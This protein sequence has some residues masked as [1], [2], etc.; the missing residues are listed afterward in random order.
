M[1]KLQKI[2]KKLKST[3]SD[4]KPYISEVNRFISKNEYCKLIRLD[5]PT[6]T[7]LALLPALWAI[8]FAAT[9]FWQILFYSIVFYFTATAVRGAGCIINDL[10]DI[11]YDKKVTRTKN[12]PL[13]SGAISKFEALKFLV[14]LSIFPLIVLVLLPK[15]SIITGFIAV[16]M[17]IIYPLMKRRTYFPQ[18]FLGLT[19]NLGVLIAWFA[20]DPRLS[21]TPFALYIAAAI[22]TISYDTIYGHQDI[23]DDLKV[24]IKS[25]S[26]Y[27]GDRTPEI[28]WKLYLATSV[29]I[30]I[31]GLTSYMNILF[32]L[33][34][35][36][37]V[38]QLYWQTETLDINDPKD[39]AAKFKSNVI[40]GLI[41]FA[42]ILI[43]RI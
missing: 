24:G 43:G 13:A 18:I 9:S 19:F 28:C 2:N 12:R 21:I 31:V 16:I 14:L 27:L 10:W 4:I 25:L 11:E 20:I 5:K 7:H 23:K 33:I 41:I 38:Y 36:L 39:C 30:L 42:A 17:I 26:I 15:Y 29:L 6:G 22:W 8:G 40:F 32:Y 35:A 37:G 1:K 3:F 34:S